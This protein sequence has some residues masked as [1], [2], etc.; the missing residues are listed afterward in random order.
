[1]ANNKFLLFVFEL[2]WG[3]TSCPK[4]FQVTNG[5]TRCSKPLQVFET[6]AIEM[7]SFEMKNNVAVIS[8]ANQGSMFRGCLL[9]VYWGRECR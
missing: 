9:R 4:Q 7:E 5:F 3:E 6:D 2:D 8:S 1:M